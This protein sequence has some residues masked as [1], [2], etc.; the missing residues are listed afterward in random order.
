MQLYFQKMFRSFSSEPN[1]LQIS[2]DAFPQVS[3]E[4]RINQLWL[5]VWYESNKILEVDYHITDEYVKSFNGIFNGTLSYRSDS[6]IHQNF[7]AENYQYIHTPEFQI[8]KKYW[9]NYVQSAVSKQR[10]DILLRKI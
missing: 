5:L 9:E 4:V 6:F 3:S 8:N 2:Q 10:Y 1:T 7:Y